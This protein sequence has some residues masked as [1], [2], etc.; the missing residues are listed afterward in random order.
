MTSNKTI[1]TILLFLL[2]FSHQES[3]A[4]GCSDAGVCSATQHVNNN[5]DKPNLHVFSYTQSFGLGDRNAAIIGGNF[6]Y[7][8]QANKFI[9]FGLSLPYSIVI[10]NLGSTFGFGD[11]ILNTDIV[12]FSK[13]K[14]QL[15]LFLAGKIATGNANKKLDGQALPMV[16]Q[17]SSGTNDFITSLNWS[18]SDWFFAL[19]YQHPFNTNENEFIANDFPENSSAAT[20]HSSAFLKRGDDMMLRI[21]R[22][23]ALKKSKIK[24]GILPIYRLQGDEIKINDSYQKVEG[25]KGLTLNL[26][27]G[28]IH[29]FN[30][31][32]IGELQLAAPPITREVRVDGTTRTFL[33][34]YIFRISL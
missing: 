24:A 10:G 34:N 8:L 33:I 29:E 12:V 6:N 25:S 9:A 27:A 13:E 16:Y 17:Q 5:G 1:I 20:Y 11:I 4:Q 23:F 32:V 21:Q 18:R 14:D 7:R 26:Y 22:T 2:Y 31:N 28:W 19:G 3:R 15:S 30:D